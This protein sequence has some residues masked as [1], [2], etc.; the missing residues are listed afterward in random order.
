MSRFLRSA[1]DPWLRV[2]TVSVHA[3]PLAI[4]GAWETGGMNVYIREVSRHLSR[5]GVQ[6]DVFTR[7]QSEDVPRVV[8]FAEHARVIHVPAGPQKYLP[9]ELVVDHLAEFICNMREFVN[10][11]GGA[12]YD[13]VH[14]HYW[15]SGRVAGYFKNAWRAPMVAM[16]HTLSELKNQV[17]LS[18]D[19]WESDVRT[20]I[21]RLTVATADRVIASTAVDS[22]HLRDHYGADGARVTIVPCGVDSDLFSP[23]PKLAARRALGLADRP[24]ILFV[25]RIQQLKGVEVVIRAAALLDGR[26]ATDDLGDFQVVIV[27]G[28]PTA[29][30]DPESREI[31]RLQRLTTQ[32]G[33]ADRVRWIGAVDH[34]AL[35]DYY[36]AADVTVMPSTYESFGLVAV[37]SMACGTPVVAARVGGLQ[38]TIQD[39]RTGYLIPWRDPALYAER[40]AALIEQPELQRALGANAR[41]RA[42]QFGWEH[43]ARQ[44]ANLYEAMLRA[45]TAALLT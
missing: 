27:G 26:R 7:Q 17:S 40:I 18:E 12:P 4:P 24:T 1:S 33:V 2:A 11:E 3:C 14:S 36:R 8:P 23:G 31:R 32:L 34:D 20:G 16:F 25:G 5:L 38:A 10:E 45:P 28:R 41:S 44:L 6:V 35:P 39:G 19:E 29:K 43:V 21:E 30:N 37:E 22:S 13:V 42:V 9:K 15:L